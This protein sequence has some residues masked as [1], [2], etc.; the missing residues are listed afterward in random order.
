MSRRLK[1]CGIDYIER[2]YS[3][4]LWDTSALIISGEGRWEH[5]D[6]LT[7][8]KY[9]K[10]QIETCKF[11][12]TRFHDSDAHYVSLGVYREMTELKP[13]PLDKR[14]RRMCRPRTTESDLLFQKNTAREDSCRAQT[15]FVYS[16]V[17]E[18]KIILLSDSEKE[19][20][21]KLRRLLVDC[22]E[23]FSAISPVDLDLILTAFSIDEREDVAVV[24][25]DIELGFSLKCAN[26]ITP[27]GKKVGWF[28][29]PRD[30]EFL[31]SK[32]NFYRRVSGPVSSSVS[33]S[34]AGA[35]A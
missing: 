7:K 35:F 32:Y 22:G 20:Y 4:V 19:K 23:D 8:I 24:S 16:L 30:Y 14:T 29:R 11:I 31:T 25:N 18:K 12:K 21:N 6:L 3:L 34:L 26:R 2:N 28:S 27:Y 9:F 1:S 13:I 15:K 10:Q 33:S 5:H 17:D